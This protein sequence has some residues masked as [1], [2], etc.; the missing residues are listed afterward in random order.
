MALNALEEAVRAAEDRPVRRSWSI[1][2]ALAYL[3]SRKD[4]ERWPFTA[5]WRSLEI[6]DDKARRVV[7]NSNLNGI[8]RQVGVLR[9]NEP[10]AA[11]P[12][13]RDTRKRQSRHGPDDRGERNWG[14]DVGRG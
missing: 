10:T 8:Y 9:G 1:R 5:F 7:L 3:A 11:V 2:L 4:C 6:K 13:E 12:Y 14:G